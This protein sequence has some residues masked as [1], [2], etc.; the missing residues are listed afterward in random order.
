MREKLVMIILLLIFIV[1]GCTSGVNYLNNQAEEVPPND[2]DDVQNEETLLEEATILPN[3]QNEGETESIKNQ[4][5]NN[6][7]QPSGEY[8]T[9]VNS[10]YGYS[11]KYPKEWNSL[12]E[13]PAGDGVVL[14][15]DDQKEI[16]VYGGFDIDHYI[17]N[18]INEAL[19]SGF[20]VH[21]FITDYGE[22]GKLIEGKDQGK[23]RFHFIIVNKDR[24]CQFNALVTEEL[25]PECR[26]LFIKTAA[27][28]FLGES[29]ITE[30]DKADPL[31]GYQQY[32]ELLNPENLRSIELAE[33]M[34]KQYVTDDK[35]TNDNLF[36]VFRDFYNKVIGCCHDYYWRGGMPVSEEI[37]TKSGL[38][39]NHSESGEFF[40]EDP[41]YLPANF[42]STLSEGLQEFLKIRQTEF[43]QA[44][45]TYLVED[46]ALTI[47]W[48]QLSDR[49]V[50][51]QNY[52]DK[53]PDY[54]GKK[55]VEGYISFYLD[56]YLLNFGLDNTPMF[57]NGVLTDEVRMS[58]ERF[59][60]KYHG[61]KY[62]GIVK[63][64]YNLLKKHDFIITEEAK[65]Y[66]A[67][68]GIK[69]E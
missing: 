45:R 66:L 8:N 24:Q 30:I 5:T 32:V 9:Y 39:T 31:P 51:W 47:T 16:R 42:A 4:D 23:R 69:F 56:L 48:D 7:E 6:P 55:E 63:E 54:P 61:T 53:Y 17:E 43:E 50:D 57:I 58:Y 28:L 64:Y 52:L 68:N 59:I 67:D 13:S 37:L 62:H 2:S 15:S 26:D 11:L 34:Y 38:R 20:E 29:D 27:T 25:Y 22:A 60:E 10:L 36:R 40:A 33:E 18:Y 49:I 3:D 44:G 12:D 21:D 1:S 41:S 14:H 19:S 46:A 35:I 65:S